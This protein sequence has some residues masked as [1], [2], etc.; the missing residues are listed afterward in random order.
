MSISRKD[1][2][3]T[4]NHT[5]FI[6][7]NKFFKDDIGFVNVNVI[8]KQLKTIFKGQPPVQKQT[9]KNIIFAR[10]RS[11]CGM[12]RLCVTKPG[13]VGKNFYLQ[14]GVHYT[15]SAF[16]IL[17]IQMFLNS[18][19][20][21]LPEVTNNIE[22]CITQYSEIDKT[23]RNIKRQGKGIDIE[24][25][26]FDFSSLEKKG[27]YEY[28]NSFSNPHPVDERKITMYKSLH[29]QY[30]KSLWP[31]NST[32]I[33]MDTNIDYGFTMIDLHG[34]IY[35]VELKNNDKQYIFYYMIYSCNI[36][37]P[38]SIH[39]HT[40]R[41]NE[42]YVFEKSIKVKNFIV[43]IYLIPHGESDNKCL[44][45]GLY[46]TY[47]PMRL[48]SKTIEFSKILAYIQH[49]R[50]LKS[51]FVPTCTTSYKFTGYYYD[52]IFNSIK[53]KTLNIIRAKSR[54]LRR[55]IRKPKSKS[56]SRSRSRSKSKSRS[57]SKK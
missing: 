3:F 1:R 40:S 36:E 54:L 6:F 10:S 26:I 15:M 16:I 11:E 33:L 19:I 50:N 35:S 29:P 30:K 57:S 56:R 14:K 31:V 38:D 2:T 39:Q 52:T 4:L 28:N 25:C 48:L 41:T 51:S 17:E 12:W 23:L 13:D 42:E 27:N 18:I 53:V 37:I 24:K 5:S 22:P 7:E 46:D 44:E 47:V 20:D 32:S 34:S 8:S 43:P 9:S 49:C 21:K 45:F 55:T